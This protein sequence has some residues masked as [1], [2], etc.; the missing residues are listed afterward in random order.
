MQI[1]IIRPAQGRALREG[2]AA[3]QSPKRHGEVRPEKKD[4]HAEKMSVAEAMV[5]GGR[6]RLWKGSAQTLDRGLQNTDRLLDALL[7]RRTHLGALREILDQHVARSTNLGEV[8][9]GGHDFVLVFLEVRLILRERERGGLELGL[10]AVAGVHEVRARLLVGR[11][12]RVEVRY[13]LR[14]LLLQV[15]HAGLEVLAR[16]LQDVHHV[17]AALLLVA[18]GEG[19]HLR[20]IGARGRARNR[21]LVGLHKGIVAVEVREDVDGLVHGLDRVLVVRELGLEIRLRL[22]ADVLHLR[23]LFVR[24][25]NGIGGVLDRQLLLGDLGLGLLDLALELLHEHLVVGLRLRGLAELVL[26]PLLVLLFGTLLLVQAGDELLELADDGRERLAA[27]GGHRRRR[28]QLR[29]HL[30]GALA[31][32]EG[33]LLA[34]HAPRRAHERLASVHLAP[35]RRVFL[36][37]QRGRVLLV[38]DRHSHVHGLL[39]LSAILHA[40]VVHGSRVGLLRFDG[41]QVLLLVQ[42]RRLGGGL[43]VAVLLQLL[44]DLRKNGLLLVTLR[45]ERVQLRGLLLHERREGGLKLRLLVH[46]RLLVLSESRGQSFHLVNDR[47]RFSRLRFVRGVHRR[48]PHPRGLLRARVLLQE[49][50]ERFRRRVGS[51]LGDDVELLDRRNEGHPCRLSAFL[52]LAVSVELGEKLHGLLARGDRVVEVELLLDVVL[53]LLRALLLRGLDLALRLVN[54]AIQPR[55]LLREIVLAGCEVRNNGREILEPRTQHVDARARRFGLLRKPC[56][57]RSVVF[58]V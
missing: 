3:R 27:A 5:L 45:N 31:E 42:E 34:A 12:G 48:A 54:L 57:K 16:G 13:L 49:R 30:A 7:L 20:H 40:L 1:E 56:E 58:L 8:A 2:D 9:R 36:I 37:Q 11:G 43:R 15:L 22:L 18:A 50:A 10:E 24:E 35:S 6:K 23:V 25:R 26:A 33:R 19:R 41:R 52:R 55:N 14:L 46:R 53:V 47:K 29:V 4:H 32:E 17:A 38:E 28:Q 44:R 51:R 21:H 39:L